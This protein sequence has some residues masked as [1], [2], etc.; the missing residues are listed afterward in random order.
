[1]GL[2]GKSKDDKGLSKSEYYNIIFEMLVVAKRLTKDSIIRYIT[3]KFN[4]DCNNSAFEKALSKFNT[5]K[6]KYSDEIWYELN[7]RQSMKVINC[8]V[9]VASAPEKM[10]EVLDVGFKPFKDDVKAEVEKLIQNLPQKTKFRDFEKEIEA[11]G[12]RLNLPYSREYP[13]YYVFSSAV[14]EIVAEYL[15]S[16]HKTVTHLIAIK[17]LNYLK[18]RQ[19][20]E[21]YC[22]FA[23]RA[24]N[25][26][27]FS[28]DADKYTAITNEMCIEAIKV[29][30]FFEETVAGKYD[31][32]KLADSVCRAP[33]LATPS[34]LYLD[35]TL[36][37][38]KI[39][40]EMDMAAD[41]ACFYAWMY[42]S[43][44]T[45]ETSNEL[46]VI[47]KGLVDF[48]N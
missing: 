44:K 24:V 43:D 18:I 26:Y 20:E 37:W 5:V 22:A 12:S 39:M 40:G 48:L 7:D 31:I 46:E 3:F 34:N 38:G 16:G 28:D 15:T 21:S 42:I 9:S 36:D 17:T 8:K 10:K 41:A 32:H 13:K 11:Y 6:E 23:A 25:F 1:M 4:D 33:T 47:I 35:K 27:K 45:G 19:S 30:G 14:A 2:F 29:S